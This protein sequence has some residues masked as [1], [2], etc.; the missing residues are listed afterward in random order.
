MTFF[1][2]ND[3]Q[4]LAVQEAAHYLSRQLALE[5]QQTAV[6]REPKNVKGQRATVGGRRFLNT[7]KGVFVH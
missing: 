7:K 1:N 6:G 3:K 4:T 5:G 2:Q